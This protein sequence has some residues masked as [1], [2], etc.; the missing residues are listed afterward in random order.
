MSYSPYEGR[1]NHAVRHDSGD[2]PGCPKLSVLLNP[3]WEGGEEGGGTE[4]TRGGGGGRGIIRQSLLG[5]MASA[6]SV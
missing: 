4:Q 3:I 5:L 1:K 2:A 6:P